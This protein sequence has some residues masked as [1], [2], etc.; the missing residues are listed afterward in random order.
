VIPLFFLLLFVVIGLPLGVIVLRTGLTPRSVRSTLVPLFYLTWLRLLVWFHLRISAVIY[1]SGGFSGYAFAGSVLAGWHCCSL[2]RPTGWFVANCLTVGWFWFM[3]VRSRWDGYVFVG[4]TDAGS[5]PL[6]GRDTLF[7]ITMLRRLLFCLLLGVIRCCVDDSI[8]GGPSVLCHWLLLSD[9]CH[10]G[11]GRAVVTR[12]GHWSVILT[13]D[14]STGGTRCCWPE[15]LRVLSPCPTGE[16]W[17]VPSLRSVVPHICSLVRYCYYYCSLLFFFIVTIFILYALL[18]TRCSLLVPL[19]NGVFCGCIVDIPLLVKFMILPGHLLLHSRTGGRLLLPFTGLPPRSVVAVT[20]CVH[21]WFGCSSLPFS[22]RLLPPFTILQF[23]AVWLRSVTFCLITLLGISSMDASAC[24]SAGDSRLPPLLQFLDGAFV[25][26]PRYQTV[27]PAVRLFLPWCLGTILIAFRAVGVR[28]LRYATFTIADLEVPLPLLFPFSLPLRWTLWIFCFI[29][30]ML[31]FGGATICRLPD[32]PH[33][34]VVPFGCQYTDYW[35]CIPVVILLWWFKFCRAEWN[36][37]IPVWLLLVFW[38][39]SDW[40]IWYLVTVPSSGSDSS[41]YR[42][43]VNLYRSVMICTL[44][45]VCYHIVTD[46]GD[47][48]LSITIFSSSARCLFVLF[49]NGCCWLCHYDDWVVRYLFVVVLRFSRNRPVPLVG[50]GVTVAGYSWLPHWLPIV[51]DDL[52]LFHHW[53]R[54]LPH[55]WS[56]LLQLVIRCWI[57]VPAAFVD[58]FD[59]RYSLAVPENDWTDLPCVA[60]SW[61]DTLWPEYDIDH[62]LT[63]ID[64]VVV[65]PWLRLRWLREG[66]HGVFVVLLFVMFWSRCHF[67]LCSIR[68]SITFTFWL[69]CTFCICIR[70]KYLILPVIIHCCLLLL[71]QISIIWLRCWWWFVLT[72]AFFC[73]TITIVLFVRWYFFI[74]IWRPLRCWLIRCTDSFCGRCLFVF[75]GYSFPCTVGYCSGDAT[76]CYIC[77]MVFIITTIDVTLLLRALRCIWTVVLFCDAVLLYELHLNSGDYCCYVDLMTTVYSWPS[78]YR[79]IVLLTIRYYPLLLEVFW[80]RSNSIRWCYYT[81]FLLRWFFGWRH[82]C[83]S[84][85]VFVD[86]VFVNVYSLITLLL[87]LIVVM[88]WYYLLSEACGRWLCNSLFCCSMHWR[89]YIVVFDDPFLLTLGWWLLG[90]LFDVTFVGICCSNYTWRWFGGNSYSVHWAYL[91]CIS[92]EHSE[93]YCLMTAIADYSV[94]WYCC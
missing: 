15:R 5:P 52:W 6:F 50:G 34:S 87:L 86:D 24:Y 25:R 58:P 27:I 35:F 61:P 93:L 14:F 39:C 46:S 76:R 21:C 59:W 36:S 47:V 67:V 51:R 28:S 44:P 78:R 3:D 54:P 82:Y 55:V 57:E 56:V 10:C 69:F 74:L 12:S 83:C 45:V 26:S 72:W 13:Y 23:S 30:V 64:C 53:F 70:W 2:V 9:C 11:A 19:M 43:V 84:V 42:S 75:G 32:L 89:W 92:S 22:L 62:L 79:Y 68:R 94:Y 91:P 90:T 20:D 37:I 18:I 85:W 16:R 41:P 81:V 80:S 49:W 71:L 40:V 60:G 63:V 38:R 4:I 31:L 77:G 88:E 33:C 65:D 73:S 48:V 29:T 17:Y 66:I 7:T 8:C 1:C